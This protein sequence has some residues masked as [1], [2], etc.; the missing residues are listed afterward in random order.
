MFEIIQKIGKGSSGYVYSAINKKDQI[1]YALKQSS[2]SENDELIKNEV[3]I[4]KML[5]NECPYIVNFYDFFKSKNE[6]NQNCLCIQMEYCQFGSIREIIK[7][8]RKKHI[9]ITEIELSS[10]IYM[11]LKGINFIHKKKL[12]NRDIKGRNI[13]INKNGYVKLCDFGI[14]KPYIENKMKNLR[15][16]SPYWMAPEILN[17]EEY[18]Q[19]IDIWA[20]GITC[21]EL[22]EY[23]PPYSKLSP[24]EV[25][26]KIVKSPPKGLAYPSKWSNEFNNFISL[27]LTVDKFK[28]PLSDELLK[29]DFINMIDK[30]NINRRLIIMQFLSKCGYKVLYNRKTM[31]KLIPV[32]KKGNNLSRM[33]SYDNMLSK[34]S[35]STRNI[36][37]KNKITTINSSRNIFSKNIN[38]N[39]QKQSIQNYTIFNKK[40]YIRARSVER[41]FSLN[42]NS[43]NKSINSNSSKKCYFCKENSHIR[44]QNLNGSLRKF[45]ENNSLKENKNYEDDDDD[46]AKQKILD[47]K[48]QDLIKE[49]DF[50]INNI[51]TKYEDRISRMKKE[52]SDLIKKNSTRNEKKKNYIDKRVKTINLGDKNKLNLRNK[53]DNNSLST[54]SSK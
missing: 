52:Q 36:H 38:I 30:K 26:K 25:M 43:R 22:A 5:E 2:S 14:C 11:V 13:L 20:L 1:I 46:Y 49:R 29:H 41:K 33:N 12:V 8:G 31:N 18:N 54:T 37:H 4:Y 48:I 10:I 21:I 6:E 24:S 17:K 19:S 34:N 27:C 47:D 16:G 50:E 32:F 40:I 3:T 39:C 44:K 42:K 7:Q 51:I 23:E 28:R 45:T 15:G 9:Q 35:T 53:N